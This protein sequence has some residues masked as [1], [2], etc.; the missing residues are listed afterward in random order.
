MKIF[1]SNK[2]ISESLHSDTINSTNFDENIIFQSDKNTIPQTHKLFNT[3]SLSQLKY[4][5]I[6]TKSEADLNS[7]NILDYNI[8]NQ[9]VLQT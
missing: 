7:Q 1:D 4:P 5:N 9:K 2:E 8:N 6:P 3:F